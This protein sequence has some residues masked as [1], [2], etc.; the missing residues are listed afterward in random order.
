[1]ALA[2]ASFLAA[3]MLAAYVPQA[4]L[5]RLDFSSTT[6]YIGKVVHHFDNDTLRWMFTA[7]P[8]GSGA[9]REAIRGAVLLFLG[10][11]RRSGTAGV[12][13]VPLF[14]FRSRRVPDAKPASAVKGGGRKPPKAGRAATS[15]PAGRTNGPFA[16][17]SPAVL[18]FPVIMTANYLCMS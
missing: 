1:L 13:L 12:R 17:L 2:L 8:P 4:P 11:L 3:T 5:V 14:A 10:T 16:E 9:V 7:S 6:I 18:L 15:S